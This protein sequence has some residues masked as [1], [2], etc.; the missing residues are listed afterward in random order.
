MVRIATVR[1]AGQ[2]SVLNKMLKTIPYLNYILCQE[3]SG[4][5]AHF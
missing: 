5:L 2:L 1:N 4:F 3:T